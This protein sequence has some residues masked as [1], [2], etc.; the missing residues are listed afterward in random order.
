MEKDN[1]IVSELQY[2]VNCNACYTILNYIEEVS[3]DRM[4]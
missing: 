2:F 3:Y 1:V 4:N